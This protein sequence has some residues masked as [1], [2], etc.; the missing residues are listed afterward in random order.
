M[1]ATTA[2][3]VYKCPVCEE[4]LV[5]HRCPDCNVFEQAWE[6]RTPVAMTGETGHHRLRGLE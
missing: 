6:R 2:S 5:E 4:R 1:E 3:V